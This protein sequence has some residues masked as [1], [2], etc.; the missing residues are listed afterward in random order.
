MVASSY[1][2]NLTS[3]IA[4]VRT[5]TGDPR[6]PVVVAKVSPIA[7]EYPYVQIV[8]QGMDSVANECRCGNNYLSGHRA[9]D[10]SH[11]LFGKWNDHPGPHWVTLSLASTS[12]ILKRRHGSATWTAMGTLIPMILMSREPRDLCA[13]DT[14]MDGDTDIEDLLNVIG[15][16]GNTCTP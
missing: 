3:L 6:L 14:D 16:W 12:L 5:A 8:H 9:E 11:P 15:S 13:S 1:A 4:G 7:S 2:D 10:R